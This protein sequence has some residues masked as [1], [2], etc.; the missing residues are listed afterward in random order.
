MKKSDVS[1]SNFKTG[2]VDL[3]FIII[4][5]N[6]KIHFLAGNYVGKSSNSQIKMSNAKPHFGV[7]PPVI[8]FLFNQL[9]D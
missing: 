1:T 2:D 8:D 9:S 7:E 4:K 6:N 5:K 3:M